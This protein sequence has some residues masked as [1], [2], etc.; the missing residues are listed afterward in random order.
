MRRD[1]PWIEMIDGYY[2]LVLQNED[3]WSTYGPVNT[4][5]QKLRIH[6]T[7]KEGMTSVPAF[8]HDWTFSKSNGKKSPEG[9]LET[10][11]LEQIEWGLATDCRDH[12]KL[13]S[14]LKVDAESPFKVNLEG[15]P[16]A[17]ETI[18]VT[19]AAG[20][21]A[22]G[23][24]ICT[25]DRKVCEG[26]CGGMCGFCGLGHAGQVKQTRLAVIDQEMFNAGLAHVEEEP[27]PEFHSPPKPP[28]A[29][30][31]EPIPEAKD[32][33]PSAEMADEWGDEWGGGDEWGDDDEGGAL[34]P[35]LVKEH[36][37]CGPRGELLTKSAGDISEC[38]ALVEGA[39]Y[40]AFAFGVKFMRGRCYA[41]TLDVDDDQVSEW[42]K[43]RMHPRCPVG[44]WKADKYF[45]F[46]ALEKGWGEE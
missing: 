41:M 6:G 45:D 26:R 27:L 7:P 42:N 23:E 33:E 44:E 9:D 5:W 13:A 4:T 35:Q 12:T 40:R 32:P 34:T 21:E 30:M 8:L 37:T 31:T 25:D 3:N 10:G 17:F 43:M 38:G 2:Y 46:Y 1:H 19:R 11:P 15:T 29:M 16:F 28:K 39:G 14:G 18:A 24:V 22:H 36:A 20:H